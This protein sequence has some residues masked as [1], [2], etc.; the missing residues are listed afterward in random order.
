MPPD[1]RAILSLHYLEGLGVAAIAESLGVPAG[2]VK[3]RLHHAR[4]QLKRLWE[5][6][7]P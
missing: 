7:R 3:S 6:V 1:R 4:N 2:T 5:G